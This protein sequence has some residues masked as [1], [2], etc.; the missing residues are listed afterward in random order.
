MTTR[1]QALDFVTQ[2]ING[3]TNAGL[4]H[5]RY[6]Y[7]FDTNA[8]VNQNESTALDTLLSQLER[9][10]PSPYYNVTYSAWHHAIIN[11]PGIY[12]R[13]A[14]STT[15]I[16]VGLG[17]DSVVEAGMALHHTYGTPYLPGSALKGLAAS[18]ARQHLG[19]AW[20]VDSAAYAELFGTQTKSGAVDFLDARWDPAS[21]GQVLARDIMS[22]HQFAYYSEDNHAPSDAEKLNIVPFM[23]VGINQCFVIPLAGPKNWCDAA[24]EILTQALAREGIGAKTNAGYGRMKVEV[25]VDPN[26][27]VINA[28]IAVTSID[29]VATTAN[30]RPIVDRALREFTNKRANMTPAQQKQIAQMLCDAMQLAGMTGSSHYINMRNIADK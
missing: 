17:V 29:K 14:I 6:M 19:D 2:P 22:V 25:F 13:N 1:R 8:N 10:L 28:F 5:D 11:T 9:L 24:F 23:S 4:W 20:K 15:R 27:Q 30:K 3:E 18:F 12:L 26:Q 21:A 16:L 7:R